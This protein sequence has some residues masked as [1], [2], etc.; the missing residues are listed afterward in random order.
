[1]NP[2]RARIEGKLSTLMVEL[3]KAK[4]ENKR[5]KARMLSEQVEQAEAAADRAAHAYPMLARG[6]QIGLALVDAI[7]SKPYPKHA[8]PLAQMIGARLQAV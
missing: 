3:K 2:I 4:E 6:Q 7:A 5:G 1:M 8:A